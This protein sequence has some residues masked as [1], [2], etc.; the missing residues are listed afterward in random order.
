VSKQSRIAGVTCP[1]L[2]TAGASEWSTQASMLRTL[3]TILVLAVTP[4]C[5]SPS[6]AP[7]AG[8][9]GGSAAA[10][11][12]SSDGGGTAGGGSAGGGAGGGAVDA[13]AP[14][15]AVNGA[16]P[17]FYSCQQQ[18]DCKSGLVCVGS[19]PGTFFCKP[20]CTS[21]A[22]CA[23][24]QAS[25]P[26][27][28]C[29]ANH[30]ANGPGAVGVCNDHPLDTLANCCTAPLPDAGAPP[31]AGTWS[32][33]GGNFD[34][35]TGATVLAAQGFTLIFVSQDPALAG[36]TADNLI[37]AFFSSIPPESARF[38]PSCPHTVTMTIDPAYSGVAATT[39]SSITVSASYIDANVE[40][41]DIIT[42]EDMHVVQAYAFGS[43]ATPTYW[44]EGIADYA[45]YQYGINN[46]AAG[47][48]LPPYDA[49]QNYTDSYRVT[50]RFLVWLDL[51]VKSGIVD[52]LDATLR[53]G[54]YTDTFWV[55]QTGQTL[56]QLWT[57]YGQNP[58]L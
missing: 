32:M 48:S 2:R 39:G 4:A 52:T 8:L 36:T 30:C 3:S 49:T 1:G 27:V 38:N 22:D 33:N 58:A 23:P 53:S 56:A 20:L 31:D 50:A 11:G 37:R 55:T 12:G 18:S 26:T 24:W 7:D 15:T 14:C 57:S 46:A 34:G 35:G 44:V 29:M 19:G 41:Y 21:N 16:T 43:S 6:P 5:S 9:G 17:A 25:L 10:G 47:W 28:H 51:H 45:R 42:H 40:D 54:A 13:G